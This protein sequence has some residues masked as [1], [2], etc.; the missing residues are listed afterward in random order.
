MPSLETS[1]RCGETGTPIVLMTWCVA[2]STQDTVSSST[3]PTKNVLPSAVKARPPRASLPTLNV[4]ISV[5]VAVS[6]IAISGVLFAP[7]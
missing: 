7:T 4:F 6:T 1:M 3:L 2:V 5:S